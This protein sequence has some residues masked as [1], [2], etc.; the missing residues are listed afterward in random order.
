MFHQPRKITNGHFGACYQ[1]QH[2]NACGD[3]KIDHLLEHLRVANL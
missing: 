3:S 2:E 1:H